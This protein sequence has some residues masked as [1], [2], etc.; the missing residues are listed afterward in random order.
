MASMD[1]ERKQRLDDLLPLL[2]NG[3]LAELAEQAAALPP[4]DLAGLLENLSEDDKRSLFDALDPRIAAEVVVELSD[5]SREQVLEDIA[6]QRLA[7][8]VD[9]LPSDEATDIISELAPQQARE[10]L[11]RIDLQDSAEV[12][13]LLRYPEDSAGG[14][15]QLEL[16]AARPETT[17]GWVIAEV[18]RRKDEIGELYNVFVVDAAY[19]VL[20]HVSVMELLLAPS[21]TLCSALMT[22]C[23]LI[24]RVDEDQEQMAHKFRRYDVPSAPVVDAEGKLLGRITNDDVLEILEEEIREDLLRMAGS[25]AEDDMFYG[26]RVFKISRLRLPWLLTNL[27][28]GLLTGWLLWLFKATLGDAI[29]L[30]TFVP[31]ITAMGGNVGI[32]S[33]TIMVRGF[34]VGRV[35]YANLARLLWREFK[36]AI[37][38]GLSCGLVVGGA[39]QLWHGNAYLGLVVGLAMLAAITAAS[40]M[41]TLAPAVFRRLGVDPAI[42]SG[43]FV[44]T[45]NDIV[46]IMIYL[47]I[48]TVFYS[49]L[50]L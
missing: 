8:I 34:A 16:V 33:A 49:R 43:P 50:A 25:S 31:V 1:R 38:M 30:V 22:A 12:R 17:V 45:A 40:L 21:S 18:R 14:V 36:V 11:E 19:R 46:G 24:I 29:V 35:T 39:A 32:Q 48:A 10:V 20:G 6:T 4:S 9:D 27:F 44:T 47:S 28:G 2:E 7:D 26:D 3:R 42:S 37:V 41:G 13:T 23:P 15:M 5:Y